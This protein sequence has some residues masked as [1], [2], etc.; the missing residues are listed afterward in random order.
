MDKLLIEFVCDKCHNAI[1]PCSFTYQLNMA[2]AIL[3]NYIRIEAS[4]IYTSQLNGK[5]A[6]DFKL[7]GKIEKQGLIELLS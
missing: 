6:K 1:G 2:L 3:K 5:Y 7:L 4:S